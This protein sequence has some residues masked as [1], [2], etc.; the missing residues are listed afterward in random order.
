MTEGRMPGTVLRKWSRESKQ[1][2]RTWMEHIRW[3]RKQYRESVSR[4]SQGETNSRL[5]RNSTW[6][7]D[8]PP[9]GNCGPEAV[10]HALAMQSQFNFEF[11]VQLSDYKQESV[12][13]HSKSDNIAFFGQKPSSVLTTLVP[14]FPGD[15]RLMQFFVVTRV[16][17]SKA[18]C[19]C[20]C[21]SHWCFVLCSDFHSSSLSSNSRRRISGGVSLACTIWLKHLLTLY[22]TIL[23]NL[24]RVMFDSIAITWI[25][26]CSCS[27]SRWTRAS[28]I[29]PTLI[30]L[31][32]R[33]SFTRGMWPFETTIR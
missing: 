1:G 20:Y 18:E 5:T 28:P 26:W 33:R 6:I 23:V 2:C 25:I 4:W 27:T 19:H 9:S 32:R 21:L 15:K 24:Q 3:E 12:P 11:N 17:V 14:R 29:N 30:N 8:R 10:P 31:P 22:F 13:G 7:A 16:Y